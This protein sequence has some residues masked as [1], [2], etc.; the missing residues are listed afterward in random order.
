MRQVKRALQ[1]LEGVDSDACST[2]TRIGL[3][4]D[5]MFSLPVSP[6]MLSST[7]GLEGEGDDPSDVADSLLFRLSSLL[8]DVTVQSQIIQGMEAVAELGNSL[9]TLADVRVKIETSPSSTTMAF[10]SSSALNKLNTF[11]SKPNAM[12]SA[13]GYKN[14]KYPLVVIWD[15]YCCHCCGFSSEIERFVVPLSLTL[16]LTSHISCFCTGQI[17]YERHKLEDMYLTT[18]RL[19]AHPPGDVLIWISHGQPYLF[20][21]PMQEVHAV[22]YHIARMMFEWSRIEESWVK[23]IKTNVNEVWVPGEWVKQMFIQ[24]G[25]PPG[26]LFVI[27]EAVDTNRF[28]PDAVRPYPDV[29]AAAVEL[30]WNLHCSRPRNNRGNDFTFFSNFKWEPRKG[31]ETLLEAYVSLGEQSPE[32]LETASLYI[33]TFAFEAQ[34]IKDQEKIFRMIDKWWADR[35]R[36]ARYWKKMKALAEQWQASSDNY[37]VGEA[38]AALLERDSDDADDTVALSPSSF[39]HKT[40]Q[41]AS[42][43]RQ[44]WMSK[45]P[46]LCLIVDMIPDDQMD[47]LY[48]SSDAFVIP[49]RGEGWG[50]PIIQSMALAKPV[51]ATRWGG[52]LEFMND[53]VSFFIEIDGLEQPS[54]MSQGSKWATPSASHLT[55]I[56]RYVIHNPQVA[57][58]VGVRAREHIVARY[59]DDA[60]RRIVEKRLQVI[61]DFVASL[62][63]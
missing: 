50:L 62:Y 39:D 7:G 46:R 15:Q 48:A 43:L 13:N 29:D 47:R 19:L 4:F 23:E 17:A 27:P 28:N 25:V 55:E 18:E 26:K 58:A 30:G 1:W 5:E 57:K 32:L 34:D 21:H 20:A 16:Y 6:I 40:T 10:P 38:A 37:N 44:E 42:K 61:H 59:S 8:H 41:P 24:S 3:R 35:R 49:T 54:G 51:I 31:W 22:D 2:R 12:A 45:M 14:A 36:T 52:E 60:V 11:A 33:L 56:M 63:R 9:A 53:D